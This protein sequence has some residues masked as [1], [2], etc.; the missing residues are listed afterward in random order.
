MV[1]GAVASL[2]QGGWVGMGWSLDV[3]YI[4]RDFHGSMTAPSD[5]SYNLVLN[6]VSGTLL[7]GSDEKYLSLIGLDFTRDDRPI[8]TRA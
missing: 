1:D 5:D 7:L 2:T 6:G 4:E 3:G 8:L